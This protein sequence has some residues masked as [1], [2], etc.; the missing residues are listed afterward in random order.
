MLKITLLAAA[1]F[2]CAYLLGS[3]S[4]Y[5]PWRS[6]TEYPLDFRVV[7]PKGATVATMTSERR[8]IIIVPDARSGANADLRICPEPPA[9]AA[10]NVASMLTGSASG[11]AGA[12]NG[13]NKGSAALS[14]GSS[15]A[16]ASIFARSQGI[17][18]F[19]DGSNVLCLA[20]LNDIYNNGDVNAWRSD[21]ELLL[22]TSSMLISQEIAQDQFNKQVQTPLPVVAVVPTVPNVPIAPNEPTVPIM[23]IGPNVTDLPFP[24]MIAP[25]V[26]PLVVPDPDLTK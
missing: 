2:I 4:V 20:W 24:T 13:E 25:P 22:K 21:F 9:D 19:R 6:P 26:D 14:S 23:P 12:P 18:L 1:I 7:S 10:D 11:S 8:S 15:A 5:P 17:E 16:L 3:A